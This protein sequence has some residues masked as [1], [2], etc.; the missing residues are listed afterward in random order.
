MFAATRCAHLGSAISCV[1]V[2]LGIPRSVGDGLCHS[3]GASPGQDIFCQ[4]FRNAS[5]MLVGEGR[6]AFD[7]TVDNTGRE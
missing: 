5:G 6:G 3:R 4:F 7:E 2:W 1:R